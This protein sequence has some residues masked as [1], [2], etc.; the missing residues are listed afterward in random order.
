MKKKKKKIIY[1]YME[2]LVQLVLIIDN[3]LHLGTTQIYR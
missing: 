1:I 3:V 2:E